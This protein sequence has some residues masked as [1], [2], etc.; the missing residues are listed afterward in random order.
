M[1]ELNDKLAEFEAA[2][3]KFMSF[4]EETKSP[5]PNSL[6]NCARDERK[7]NGQPASLLLYSQYLHTVISGYRKREWL[8]SHSLLLNFSVKQHM[9]TEL[10][11]GVFFFS[12]NC[13]W[14]KLELFIRLFIHRLL[15]SWIVP[16]PLS[17]MSLQE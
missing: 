1:H 8:I 4:P 14:K 15:D 2:W 3:S 9:I 11:N 12:L 7:E 6:P 16:Y 13:L 5:F 10:W 17:E